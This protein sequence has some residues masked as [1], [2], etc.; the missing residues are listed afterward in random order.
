[1]IYNFMEVKSS[2]RRKKWSIVCVPPLVLFHTTFTLLLFGNVVTSTNGASNS[3]NHKHYDNTL[4]KKLARYS[5]AAYCAPT[6]IEKWNFGPI[7]DALSDTDHVKVEE[8]D[9]ILGFAAFDSELDAIVVSFRGSTT[10][11]GWITNLDFVPVNPY[12]NYPNV[13]VQLGYFLARLRFLD[14]NILETHVKKLAQKR[15]KQT[16][17]YFTGHSMGGALALLAAFETVIDYNVNSTLKVKG[18]YTYG[19]PFMSNKA[20]RAILLDNDVA[21]WQV[22]HAKDPIPL[23]GVEGLMEGAPPHVWYPNAS[24][25]KYLISNGADTYDSACPHF[26]NCIFSAQDHLLYMGFAISAQCQ[27]PIDTPPLIFAYDLIVRYCNR[28][29]FC[30]H[31]R[32]LHRK[33]QNATCTL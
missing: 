2:A 25:D 33:T 16:D 30:A 8:V 18:V 22:I 15:G 27:S 17:V 10:V 9:D 31:S 4:S 13:S 11:Q 29:Y 28:W 12:K 24:D 1:M 23:I 6:N 21:S 26:A 3:A 14:P 19:A 5:S 20:F 7:S 32:N